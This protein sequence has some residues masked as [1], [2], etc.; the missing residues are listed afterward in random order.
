MET[1]ILSAFIS[2]VSYSCVWYLA[3][4][5]LV[6]QNLTFLTLTSLRFSTLYIFVLW[7]YHMVIQDEGTAVIRIR[8]NPLLPQWNL[9]FAAFHVA[10]FTW[11]DISSNKWSI[12]N[13]KIAMPFFNYYSLSSSAAILSRVDKYAVIGP[14]TSFIDDDFSMPLYTRLG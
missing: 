11:V 1:T 10:S 14:S 6:S 7:N 3:S 2:A 4:D 12:S 13:V 9:A 5:N 8:F